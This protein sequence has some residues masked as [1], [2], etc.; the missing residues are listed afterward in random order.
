MPAS[1]L[2][3]LAAALLASQG[4]GCMSTPQA[5]RPPEK[6]TASP[7]RSFAK[8]AATAPMADPALAERAEVRAFIAE[9]VERHG[10]AAEALTALLARAR[11]L[12]EV[13]RLIAPA[14]PGVR[15]DWRTYRA[16]VIDPIR[17]RAGLRFWQEHAETLTRAQAQWGVPPEIVVS[18]IGVETLYGRYTG[19]FRVLDTLYTLAFDEPRRFAFF[20]EELE[21]F[22]VLTREQ[23]IDPLAPKGSFAGAIGIPQFMPGSIRRHAT[24]FDGDGRIDLSASP[25]DAIGSVARFLARHG[26]RPGEP[27]HFAATI[28]DPT[29]LG[30]LIAAGIEPERTLE[31]LARWG[32]SSPEP[33]SPE[34]RLALIDLPNG[35]R[36]AS[37]VLGARNFYVVTRYNRSSFYAM[38]VIDFAQ[39]LAA[40]RDTQAGKTPVDR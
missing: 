3:C 11:R 24:D 28:E 22:L 17:I 12:P 40:L 34:M 13:L 36:P 9:M 27:T 33:I 19:S 14:Q 31:E 20:R 4:L 23:G 32:V 2:R 10:F 15:K 16:R 8:P 25:V 26:W 29:R 30:P 5:A 37:H 1:L 18:I 39:T 7:V 21:H 35:E 38:S 6:P